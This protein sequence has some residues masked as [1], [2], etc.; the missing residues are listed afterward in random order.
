METSVVEILRVSELQRLRKVRQLGLAHLVFPGAEHSRLAHSIG[1]AYLSLRFARQL[2][3]TTRGYLGEFF[4]PDEEKTRDLAIA[5]LCHDLGHG[6]LSLLWE[7]EIIEDGHDFDRDQ[8]VKALGLSDSAKNDQTLD[9]SKLKWH[10]L[11]AQGLLA[12]PDGELH[13][14]LEQFE[15]GTSTRIRYML[16]GRFYVPYFPRLLS[17]D[18]DVDRCDFILRD[19]HQTGV[20]Y[21]LF[22][23]DWLV[24]TATVGFTENSQLVFGFDKRKAPPVIEQFLIARRSLYRTVYYHKTVRGVEGMI[25]LLFRRLKD[26]LKQNNRAWPHDESSSFD[27]YRKVALGEPLN[28]KEILTLDDYSLWVLIDNLSKD[29]EVDS[30]VADLATRIVKRDIFKLVP[31]DAKKVGEKL[32]QTKFRDAFLNALRQSS[33]GDPTYYYLLD[34][35]KFSTLSSS[36]RDSAYFIDLSDRRRLATKVSDHQQF[37]PFGI[38]NE[39]E[40]MNLYV[41]REALSNVIAAIG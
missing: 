31:C 4:Q 1:A 38:G 16:A 21:G 24:S 18:V 7:R 8:W 26:V 3:S 17:S 29:S 15:K 32:S 22:D 14:F 37:R 6:P 12:W 41:P 2:S 34:K 33:F 27:A 10:E 19:A 11:V 23:L 5:T 39:D 13:N 35:V 25:G 36:E 20:A 30:I 28:P 40:N 9:Y